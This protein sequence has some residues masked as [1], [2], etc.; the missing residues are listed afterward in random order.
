M[1]KLITLLLILIVTTNSYGLFDKTYEIHFDV[2][3]FNTAI[4][5]AFDRIEKWLKK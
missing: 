3:A 5:E 4:D 1:K 2:D